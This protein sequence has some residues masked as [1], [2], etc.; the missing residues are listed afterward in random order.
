M[1][2]V[3]RLLEVIMKW[4]YMVREF[5]VQDSAQI[6]LLEEFLNETGA[7]GWEL[8]H[9]A[10]APADASTHL[11][12]LRRAAALLDKAGH[13]PQSPSWRVPPANSFWN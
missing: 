4:E 5:R 2:P 9:V 8:V 11:V 1:R 3:L 13:T 10:P 12:Y 6:A 7:E